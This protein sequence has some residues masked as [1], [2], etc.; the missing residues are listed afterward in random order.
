[1]RQGVVAVEILGGARS[2]DRG[3]RVGSRELPITIRGKIESLFQAL[4]YQAD[5]QSLHKT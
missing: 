2:L 3:V 4:E 5:I 1:M